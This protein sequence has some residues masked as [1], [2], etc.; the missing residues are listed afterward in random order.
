MMCSRLVLEHKAA[1]RSGSSSFSGSGTWPGEINRLGN[2]EG[3]LSSRQNNVNVIQ[4]SRRETKGGS[5]PVVKRSSVEEVSDH[6]KSPA[7]TGEA[8]SLP[9]EKNRGHVGEHE[10]RGGVKVTR[11]VTT[12]VD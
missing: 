6:D 11:E 1:E 12:F 8:D 4:L 3:S 10:S 2:V 5:L 9:S 7:T